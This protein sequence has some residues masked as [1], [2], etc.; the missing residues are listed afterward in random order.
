M[1][2]AM[3]SNEEWMKTIEAAQRADLE[4]RPRG[5]NWGRISDMQVSRLL[6]GAIE[7]LVDKGLLSRVSTGG[8]GD[9]R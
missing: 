7:H 3:F 5:G 1:S 9:R 4:R 8:S 6:A 2:A